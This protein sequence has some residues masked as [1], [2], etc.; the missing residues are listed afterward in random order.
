[1]WEAFVHRC[2]VRLVHK[3]TLLKCRQT[4]IELIL[5]LSFDSSQLPDLVLPR[6]NR[7]VKYAEII[8]LRCF[9]HCKGMAHLIQLTIIN[10]GLENTGLIYVF[11]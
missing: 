6:R 9:M 4:E 8:Y 11:P 5:G 2:T 7:V 1:M 10:K 3:L